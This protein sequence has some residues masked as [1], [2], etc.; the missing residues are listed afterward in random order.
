MQATIARVGPANHHP[1]H[2][3][4]CVLQ[5]AKRND[6]RALL[7][8]EEAEEEEERRAAEE[9]EFARAKERLTL[10]HKCVCGR[11]CTFH[12]VLA[13]CWLSSGVGCATT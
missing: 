3:C 10:K 1:P 9:A 5:A 6:G 4:T 11:T 7:D 2:T 8:G 13:S 12:I